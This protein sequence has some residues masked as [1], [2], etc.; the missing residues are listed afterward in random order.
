MRTSLALLMLLVTLAVAARPSA[1]H[2]VTTVYDERSMM[3]IDAQLVSL[4]LRNPHS[5][6]QVTVRTPKKAEV[7][8]EIEWN[9]A[10]SLRRAGIVAT[11]LHAGDRIIL[12]GQPSR[13]LTAQRLRLTSLRR[14]KD[15]L[16]WAEPMS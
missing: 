12:T 5:F 6:M 3:T 8:Y 10:D 16:V 7:R 2:D 13:P 15:G 9:G 1:H 4:A 11:T 14:P